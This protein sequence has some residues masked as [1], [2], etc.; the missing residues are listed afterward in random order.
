[1]YSFLLSVHM[2][3]LQKTKKKKK[4]KKPKTK[5]IGTMFLFKKLR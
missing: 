1:M 5:Q 2:L 4:K 3:S